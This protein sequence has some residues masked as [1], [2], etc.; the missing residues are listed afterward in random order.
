MNNQNHIVS[1]GSTICI[2]GFKS[3]ETQKVATLINNELKPHYEIHCSPDNY[4][5]IFLSVGED[6]ISESALT[7]KERNALPRFQFGI[8]SLRKF[9][10]HDRAHVIQ[11]IRFFNTVDRKHEKELAFNIIKAMKRYGISPTI[12]GERNRLI[13]YL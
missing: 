7:A 2:S 11:A 6:V 13:T 4:G 8:P 3:N 12:V 9:P 1:S 10:I 5:T